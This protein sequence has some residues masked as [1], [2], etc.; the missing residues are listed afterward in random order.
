MGLC[1]CSDAVVLFSGEPE[2]TFV[3]SGVPVAQSLAFFC[4]VLWNNGL[5]PFFFFLF[6]LSALYRFTA[7][8]QHLKLFLMVDYKNI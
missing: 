8:V 5:L 3:F 6:V 2:F 1:N 4:S 7:S